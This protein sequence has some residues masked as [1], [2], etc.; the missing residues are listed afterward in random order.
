MTM[1]VA[2]WASVD[3][4]FP[5]VLGITYWTASVRSPHLGARSLISAPPPTVMAINVDQLTMMMAVEQPRR[6]NVT[7]PAKFCLDGKAFC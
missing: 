2:K 7:D 6:L 5:D 3:A 4:F 1:S